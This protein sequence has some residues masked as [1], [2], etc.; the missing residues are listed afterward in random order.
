[1]IVDDCPVV[2][3]GLAAL[4]GRKEMTMVAEAIDGKAVIALFREHR[5]GVTLMDLR[6]PTMDCVTAIAAIRG[7]FPTVR[8]I[9][10]TTYGG[11]EDIYRG[12][13]VSAKE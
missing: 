11:D 9:V 4:L 1:M 8:I 10:L 12:L 5:P 7:A 6:M 2:C 13:R 3:E